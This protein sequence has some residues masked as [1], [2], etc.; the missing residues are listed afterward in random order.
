MVI[1][2]GMSDKIG[3]RTF[4]DSADGYYMDAT[5][6]ISQDTSKII[7][8]EVKKLIEDAYTEVKELIIQNKAKLERIALR[9]LERETLTGEEVKEIFEGKELAKV[10]PVE[11]SLDDFKM[12]GLPTSDEE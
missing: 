12:G 7:D 1:K 3:L 8:A 5:D 11:D 6:Q 9:L 10:T 4:Y 2:W